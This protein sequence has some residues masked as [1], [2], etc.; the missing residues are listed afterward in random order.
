MTECWKKRKQRAQ[1]G[2]SLLEVIISMA[3]T[4]VGLL[5]VAG[6]FGLAMATT[7]SSQQ[8]MIA[9]QLANEAYDSILTARNTTEINW[10]QLQ[11]VGSTSCPVT[12]ASSCGIFLT[13]LQSIYNAGNDGIYGTADD[14]ASGARQTLH[15]PGP[16]GIYGTADDVLIP[17]SGYQRQI[18]ISSVNATLRSVTITIQYTTPQSI[19][20]TYILNSYFSEYF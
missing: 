11:N 4:T 7:Q 17:L 16:D 5:S 10:D 2:F 12:G 8:D 20:K 14:S 13:G 6:V 19:N 1:A 3:I 15:D 9:K 18:A